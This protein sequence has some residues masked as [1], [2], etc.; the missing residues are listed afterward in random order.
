M[1]NMKKY[2]FIIL[3]F[4]VCKLSNAQDT[5]ITDFAPPM[6]STLPMEMQEGQ[7]SKNNIVYFYDNEKN[8]RREM[9]VKKVGFLNRR[10]VLNGMYVEYRKDGTIICMGAF[11]KNKKEGLW[12]NY[13]VSGKLERE[14]YWKND[15]EINYKYFP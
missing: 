8:L 12:K 13:N 1:N 15:K 10:Y 7:L 14:G 11:V 2:A 5:I 3:L 4:L 9:S 6:K